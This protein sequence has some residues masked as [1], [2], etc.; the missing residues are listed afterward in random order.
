MV[1]GLQNIAH[2]L[3]LVTHIGDLGAQGP[4][5]STCYAPD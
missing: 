1:E 2:H 4:H 3:N 5:I